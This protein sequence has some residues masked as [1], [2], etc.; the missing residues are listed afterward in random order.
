MP[1]ISFTPPTNYKIPDK[2]LPNEILN[3]YDHQELGFIRFTIEGSKD[4]DYA[5]F[6]VNK[7]I[8]CSCEGFKHRT[9]CRHIDIVRKFLES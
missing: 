8:M 5:V 2:E 3:S 7:V 1:K 4:A 6:V 9:R